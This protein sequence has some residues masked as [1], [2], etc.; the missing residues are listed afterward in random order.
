MFE[1]PQNNQ[2]A[3]SVT[4]QKCSA[5]QE[6]DHVST[7]QDVSQPMKELVSTDHII[8]VVADDANLDYYLLFVQTSMYK[9]KKETRDHW[10]SSWPAGTEVFRGL[11][12]DQIVG[13]PL[14]YR[15]IPKK[16]AIVPADSVIYIC[17]ELHAQ[18]QLMLPEHVHLNIL[19]C[20][21][22]ITTLI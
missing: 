8:A 20:V 13:N 17:S 3:R 6:R 12:Y 2:T 7:T 22:E 4:M 9:L 21:D 1:Y 19:A 5:T 14:Q 16:F 10:G 15:R 11:Y 18:P